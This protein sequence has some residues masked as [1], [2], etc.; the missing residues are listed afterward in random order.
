M[1]GKV[2]IFM[3]IVVVLN[4]FFT[5]TVLANE[6]ILGLEEIIEQALDNSLELEMAAL[7]L[8]DAKVNYNK[9]K[10]NNL[11]SS[12]HLFELQSELKLLQA[13]ENYKKSRDSVI[14]DIIGRYLDIV[15]IDQEIISSE[16]DLALEERR[17]DEVQ[18]QVE[19]GYKGSLELFEQETKYLAVSN[20]IERVKYER[21]QKLRRLKQKIAVDNE[22]KI[23]LLELVLPEVWDIEQEEVLAVGLDNNVVLDMREKQ[24]E[25]AKNELEKAKVSGTP[26]L[27]LRQ[28]EI[29]LDKANLNLKQE[30]LNLEN[31]LENRHF[32]YQQSAKNLEM[33]EKSLHQSREHY[34]IIK[35]QF[36]AGLV[37][38]NDMLASELQL[39]KSKDN[40]TSAIITYYTSKLQLQ[41]A[42][43]MELEVEIDNE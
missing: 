25:L 1:L 39:Y 4:L 28:N 26:E 12:S 34:K 38:K 17:V 21:D 8:E 37:S 22:I 32:Q 40:L 33:A 43:G 7:N 27:D 20:S 42:M 23:G 2:K 24:V 9:N 29:A 5:A 6:E 30:K 10:L 41:Q 19:V 14:I 11:M 36:E 35:E 31:N 18:A 16:M 3:I 13:E 15:K